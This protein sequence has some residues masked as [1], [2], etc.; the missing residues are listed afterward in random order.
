MSG[1][2]TPR[3]RCE[4]TP[5]LSPGAVASYCL[6]NTAVVIDA[7]GS[8]VGKRR[9][10]TPTVGERVYHAEGTS[11]DVWAFDTSVGTIGNLLCSEHH[12]PLSVFSMLTRG[13]EFHAAQ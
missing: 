5:G 10:L 2:R 7:D 4:L 8:L 9:K 12:N 13:E 1:N 6:Y 3:G 11:R